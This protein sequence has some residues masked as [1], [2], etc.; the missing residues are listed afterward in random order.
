MLGRA[1]VGHEEIDPS[2]AHV[3]ADDLPIVSDEGKRVRIVAG[4]A[5]GARSPVPTLSI[6]C[7][8]RPC[9]PPARPAMPRDDA[10]ERALYVVD[11]EIDIMGDRFAP[12]GC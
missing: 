3:G 7:S 11:G 12:G 1:A 9:W 10:E 6:R 5:Y 8:P 2:F 4:A